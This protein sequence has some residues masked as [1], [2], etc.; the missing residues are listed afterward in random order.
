MPI[1]I[2]S[3][4]CHIRHLM[5]ALN[6]LDP[7][8]GSPC[9]AKNSRIGPDSWLSMADTLASGQFVRQLRSAL[10]SLY[11]PVS[12]RSHPF[13]RTLLAADKAPS[14]AEAGEALRQDLLRA[15][16]SLKPSGQ[17]VP[18]AKPWRV[19]NLLQLRYVE[20]RDP[21]DV[22][23]QLAMSKSQY[24]RE[25]EAAVDALAALVRERYAESGRAAEERVAPISPAI[26]VRA[27]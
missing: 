17:A 27:E 7:T 14:R 11:D 5:T 1:S 8:R 3:P 15:M 6:L 23:H 10:A 24:Y 18:S 2:H 9:F 13:A 19:Y 25:H 26:A 20:A 21:V 16:E 22:Q 12:L 4:P